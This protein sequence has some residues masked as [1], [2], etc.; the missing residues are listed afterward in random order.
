VIS[1]RKTALTRITILLA[2]V[3]FAAVVLSYVFVKNETNSF[4]D[5]Q[6]RKI[7]LNAGP[8]LSAG[9]QTPFP[10]DEPED[11]LVV[12]IF[13]KSGRLV[14]DSS[15]TIGMP[16]LSQLGYSDVRAAGE[17][18][19]VYRA[20]DDQ[21]AV[22]VA[23]RRSFRE[24]LAARAATGAAVPLLL[25]IP[26]A[27]LVIGWSLGQILQRLGDV[28]EEMA[29]QSLGAKNPID[30]ALVPIEIA[31][32][33]LAMNRLIGRHQDAL[34]QQRRFVSDA[35]HELRTPLTALQIQV[36]NLQAQKLGAEATE[37]AGDLREGVHRSSVLIRQLLK[38][39][40][41]D[42]PV[43]SA[44]EI[45]DLADVVRQAAAELIP[46]ASAK[47]LD[48][49]FDLD[50]CVQVSVTP[51]DLRLLVTNLLDNAVRYSSPGGSIDLRIRKSKRR[52][53]LEI[54]DT[55]C[56]I[57]AESLPRVF[58]R[59]FRASSLDVEGTGLG[60]AIAKAAADR[61]GIGISLRNRDDG[62]GVIAA[63]TFPGTGA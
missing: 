10:G 14:H 23:Q 53:M 5:T 2:V 57:P 16:Q 54:G 8:G 25:A 1:I 21:H 35:A 42:S 50:E 43:G 33:V 31:S 49:A 6:L 46:I 36:D 12:Q 62:S 28:S 20:A 18:W 19:R 4:L 37:I 29:E 60:L 59:F 27:W 58:D 11:E 34:D 3:G 17:D 52:V 56:G 15:P 7:A 32:L 13:D 41:M 51:A 61:N 63:V 22:Q 38:M 9:A 44:P 47:R 24:N 48:L 40:Q 39:A 26:L 45:I 55:G 30:A